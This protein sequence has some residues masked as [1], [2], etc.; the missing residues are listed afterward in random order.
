MVSMRELPEDGKLIEELWDNAWLWA[1]SWISNKCES[2]LTALSPLAHK[3][4]GGVAG[5]KVKFKDISDE[6]VISQRLL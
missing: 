6:A 3:V 1:E 5:C 4:T 2:R